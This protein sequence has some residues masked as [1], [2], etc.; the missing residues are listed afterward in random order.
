MNRVIIGAAL[1]VV[2]AAS[3]CESGGGALSQRGSCNLWLD[4]LESPPAT[5][6]EFEAVLDRMSFNSESVMAS[7]L[8]RLRRYVETGP[9]NA[10]V[11]ESNYLADVCLDYLVD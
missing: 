1:V 4:T 6:A 2:M 7:A 5:Q 8:G 3:G 9:T 11:D 10:A